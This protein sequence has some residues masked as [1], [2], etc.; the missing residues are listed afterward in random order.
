MTN[1]DFSKLQVGDT[2]RHVC[3]A[4]ISYVVTSHFGDRITAVRTVDITN[5]PEWLLE[6]EPDDETYT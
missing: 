4:T 5:P 1:E 6:Q 2:V 3:D